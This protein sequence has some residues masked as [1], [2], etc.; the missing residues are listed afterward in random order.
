MMVSYI[1]QGN[2]EKINS[3]DYQIGDCLIMTIETIKII[4][5]LKKTIKTEILNVSI[6]SNSQITINTFT[7]HSHAPKLKKKFSKRP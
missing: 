1:C 5:A 3:F 7:A 2:S 4:E 6:E